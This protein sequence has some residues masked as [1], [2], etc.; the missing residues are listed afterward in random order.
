MWNM[1]KRG[2]Y[3]P[4]SSFNFLAY[5]L[6]E[7]F[8]SLVEGHSSH[9]ELIFSHHTRKTKEEQTI[10]YEND[11][12][13]NVIIDFGKLKKEG[14]ICEKVKDM[15]KNWYLKACQTSP[16]FKFLVLFSIIG[17]KPAESF[18]FVNKKV[19]EIM[20]RDLG[21][22]SQREI[23]VGLMVGG[24]SDYLLYPTYIYSGPLNS[25]FSCN[26]GYRFRLFPWKVE[27]GY[28]IIFLE[29]LPIILKKGRS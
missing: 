10:S 1:K 17:K 28:E 21:V 23:S 5:H 22:N 13:G 12:L 7:S 15:I 19:D 9:F 24:I 27:D 14:I 26:E 8:T 4:F 25:S 20:K 11:C 6:S 2:I 29:T 16:V 3:F 18:H